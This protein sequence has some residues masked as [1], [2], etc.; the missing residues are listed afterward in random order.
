MGTKGGEFRNLFGYHYPAPHLVIQTNGALHYGK[1]EVDT[2]LKGGSSNNSDRTVPET[3]FKQGVLGAYQQFCLKRGL[4]PS[5]QL[6]PFFFKGYYPDVAHGLAAMAPKEFT[7]SMTDK[8][9]FKLTCTSSI[10]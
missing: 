2:I 7:P 5:P 4:A 3:G 8:N 1:Q 6:F 10:H 9:S